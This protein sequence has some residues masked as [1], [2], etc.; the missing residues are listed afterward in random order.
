MGARVN[1]LAGNQPSPNTLQSSPDNYP[2]IRFRRVRASGVIRR[3][4]TFPGVGEGAVAGA[5]PD[6]G[7][8]GSEATG[9][10]V[11]DVPPFC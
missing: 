3:R 1:D 6:A 5:I 8:S 4:G 9:D 2:A 7:V 10:M 11:G